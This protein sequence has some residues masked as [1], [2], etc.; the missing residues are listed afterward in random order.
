[1]EI[2]ARIFFL[3]LC[4]MTYGSSNAAGCTELPKLGNA[5]VSPGLLK[6]NYSSGDKLEYSCKHGY[7]S[8]RKISYICDGKK[9]IKLHEA[10]CT[11]KRCE[12][13][14]DIPNGQYSIVNGNNFVFGTT[15]KYTCK[16]GFQM[17]SRF[18]SRT[19]RL[20]GWDNHLPECEEATCLPDKIGDNIKVEGLPGYGDLF[21]FGHRLKFSC[22]E[23]LLILR[24]AK[25]IKCQSNGKWSSP[26]PKCEEVTC[27][28]NA[29]EDNII[30]QRIP[31]QE[32]SIKYGH[33][34]KFSCLHEGLFLKGK[35]NITC[36]ANGEW[37]D[38]YPKCEVKIQCGRPPSMSHENAD[39]KEMTRNEYNSG[40]KVEYVCFDKYIME[41]DNNFTCVQGEWRGHFTCLKPCTVTVDEMDKRNI[42][43]K[44]G[45]KEKIFAP[46]GDF[47]T[48]VCQWFKYKKGNTPF[49]QMCQN[50]VMPLPECE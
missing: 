24:G 34:L 25:E 7:V 37:S 13:P 31:D 12:Q 21:R 33:M 38:P 23:K 28:K 39:T 29:T 41:G 30:V 50:G 22:D 45:G 8:L 19:C 26:F 11:L 36:Q 2:Y 17:T 14:A 5:E 10:E 20:G 42:Q 1:M 18:D 48:F 44:K 27:T 32:G 15:I 4:F 40:E 47:I 43:L 35:K 16:E 46:H 49:R 3:L 6:T 9:W